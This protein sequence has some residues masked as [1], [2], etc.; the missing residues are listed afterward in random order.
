LTSILAEYADV[1]L[2]PVRYQVTVQPEP[3]AASLIATHDACILWQAKA[4]LRPE[5]LLL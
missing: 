4:L 3:V 5:D 2:D 1:V